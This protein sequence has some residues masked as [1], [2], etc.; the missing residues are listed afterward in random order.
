MSDLLS[1]NLDTTNS[2]NNTLDITVDGELTG[3]K[4]TN[5]EQTSANT[6]VRATETEFLGDLDQAGGGALT[7]SAL[8]L[9]DLGE[10]GVGGLGDDGGGETGDETGAQVDGGLEAV[11]GGLLVEGLPDGLG[12]LLVDDELGH[13]VRN[14]AE[15]SM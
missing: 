7:G 11:G 14:P 4:S 5:H 9:V 10:H 15:I 8:G 12:N 3:G 2:T 6:T 13:S 1:S